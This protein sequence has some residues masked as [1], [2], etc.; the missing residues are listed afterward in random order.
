VPRQSPS[1]AEP[2]GQP[3]PGITV[4]VTPVQ[5]WRV[6]G[7]AWR[8]RAACTKFPVDPYLAGE[9]GFGHLLDVGLIQSR[10]RQ[11]YDWSSDE[12]A[13]P[14]L[15]ALLDGETPAYA[16]DIADSAVWRFEPS[17][18]PGQC[19]GSVPASSG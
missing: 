17:S 5:P 18:L 9:H 1:A 11:L 12:L 4:W 10:A 15:H 19:A 7:D 14:A 8:C 6:S 3:C 2:S 16:W 13:L